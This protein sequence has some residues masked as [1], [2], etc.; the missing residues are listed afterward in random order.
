MSQNR[1]SLDFGRLR[2]ARGF[3]GALKYHK[4]QAQ[5]SL[6]VPLLFL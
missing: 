6:G 3:C 2:N 1:A 5:H 4:Y